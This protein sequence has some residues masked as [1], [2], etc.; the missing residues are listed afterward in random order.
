MTDLKQLEKDLLHLWKNYRV[1][2]KYVQMKLSLLRDQCKKVSRS[3]N[4]VIKGYVKKFLRET[5]NVSGDAIA[6]LTPGKVT[7]LVDD[8]NHLLQFNDGKE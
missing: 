7:L 8:D 3:K 2:P 4:H 6:V 5:K 1:K